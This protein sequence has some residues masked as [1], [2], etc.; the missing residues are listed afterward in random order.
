MPG[1]VEEE[2]EGAHRGPRGHPLV[3]SLNPMSLDVL[4]VEIRAVRA[5]EG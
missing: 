2:V 5:E 1:T 3:T 4:V